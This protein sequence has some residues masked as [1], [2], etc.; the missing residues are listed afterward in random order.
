MRPLLPLLAVALLLAAAPASGESSSPFTLGPVTARQVGDQAVRV[1]LSAG[2]AKPL[3]LAPTVPVPTARLQFVAPMLV[4]GWLHDDN[5]LGSGYGVD[6]NDSGRIDSMTVKQENGVL[7]IDQAKVEPMGQ[8]LWGPQQPYRADG[9]QRI[10][11]LGP[12]A[13]YFDVL[14][15]QP[16]VLALQM[17]HRGHIPRV[18]DLPNP[19]LEVAVFE[20]CDPI[21]GPGDFVPEPTFTLDFG[22]GV[23]VDQ[24]VMYAWEPWACERLGQKPQWMCGRIAYLPLPGNPGTKETVFTVN[25]TGDSAQVYLL[26]RID[27]A[28]EPG[29]R[30]QTDAVFGQLWNGPAAPGK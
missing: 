25:T 14:F 9:R 13:P 21:R 1:N 24:D 8:E 5:I 23:D 30:L 26:T 7:R 4:P 6:L 16:P 10:Y 19:T 12:R 3:A 15:C 28:L 20:F 17:Q 11:T 2:L 22:E 29:T 27:Y 18:R